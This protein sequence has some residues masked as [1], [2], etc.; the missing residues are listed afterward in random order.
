LTQKRAPGLIVAASHSGA[1]KTTITMGLLRAFRRRG[2]AVA[3]AKCGPDYI[4]PGLHTL[5]T[6]RASV[7]LDSWAMRPALLDAL[8]GHLESAAELVLC[9]GVMGLFDGREAAAPYGDGSTATLSARTG[10]PVIVVLDVSGQAQSAAAVAKG[11]AEFRA[12]V[13]VAGVILNRVGS[14]GHAALCRSAIEGVGLAVVGA[15]PRKDALDLPERHLGLVQAQ[16]TE[17]PERRLD[18]IADVVAAH[19]DLDRVQALAT[20]GRATDGGDARTL[21]RAFQPPGQRIAL[22]RDRAFS[23]VYPHL[24]AAWKAAGATILPFS[25]LADEAPDPSADV[26]WL[27]GGYPELHAGALAASERFLS[28]LR[29][30]AESRPVHGEC[31]GY[32]VL[33]ERLYDANGVAHHMAGLLAHETTFADR[34][35]HLGYR[36]AR[37]SSASVLGPAGTWCRGHEFH[38]ASSVGR[39]PDEPL[40]DDVEGTT[41]VCL[42]TRRGR[43]SGS[44]FHLLDVMDTTA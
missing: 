29:T 32:M 18:A 17:E 10:W 7:N 9:E 31:G 39:S 36:R 30:F 23:F 41:E 21:A 40:F 22:A 8:R 33:G 20:L 1:G 2:V 11:L 6:G 38:Y 15:L 16:E 19:V 5:A 27:P 13:R 26:C 42:G 3:S 35:L 14:A 25:P 37:L 24:L 34:K 43:V 44:F 28:G 12:D 4:D